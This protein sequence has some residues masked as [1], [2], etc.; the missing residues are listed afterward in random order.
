MTLEEV[1]GQLQSQLAHANDRIARYETVLRHYAPDDLDLEVE[2]RHVVS[3][4]DDD[5][6]T[7]WSYRPPPSAVVGGGSN[8]ADV[9]ASPQPST[10]AASNVMGGPTTPPPSAP[11]V[12]TRGPS[13]E[14][15]TPEEVT[16]R[17]NQMLQR[18]AGNHVPIMGA[19]PPSP[20][21]QIIP[22]PPG[23]G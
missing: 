18:E 22:N 4:Q 15:L 6:G 7:R 17:Y 12:R 10:V 3:W 2:T 8:V 19:P 9:V 13:I 1:V 20:A 21:G 14:D 5:E 11:S 16:A 23:L